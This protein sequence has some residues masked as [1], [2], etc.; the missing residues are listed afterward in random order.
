MKTNETTYGFRGR[1]P[2]I[3]TPYI[4]RYLIKIQEAHLHYALIR[5]KWSFHAVTLGND[6]IQV[7]FHVAEGKKLEQNGIDGKGAPKASK[8]Q[9]E[10]SCFFMVSFFFFFPSQNDS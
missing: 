10:E 3:T 1:T 4:E 2:H 8:D 6:S 5:I 7:I 9:K